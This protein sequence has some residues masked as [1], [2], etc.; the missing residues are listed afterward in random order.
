MCDAEHPTDITMARVPLPSDTCHIYYT[1]TKV[2][3]LLYTCSFDHLEDGILLD[4]PLVCIHR[5]CRGFPNDEE[6]CKCRGTTTPSAREAWKRRRKK[7]KQ[8]PRSRTSGLHPGHPAPGDSS[9]AKGKLQQELQ[10]PDIRPVARTSGPRPKY[11][12]L[13]P[14][15]RPIGARTERSQAPEPR[16]SGLLPG[17]PATPQAPGHP[18]PHPRKS[19]APHPEYIR[20]R[21]PSPGRPASTAR[22]SGTPMKPR[23]SGPWPGHPA[24]VRADAGQRPMY[25]LSLAPISTSTI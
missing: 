5:Y 22:T 16:T 24:P 10:A 1:Y 6:Q 19:G 8:P 15:I 12:A 3:H 21:R 25:P 9:G 7:A 18:G 11:P 13:A 23:T 20:N 4:T 14:D 17:H 2:N